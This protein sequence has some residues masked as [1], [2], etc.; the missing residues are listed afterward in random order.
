[1]FAWVSLPEGRVEGRTHPSYECG[2]ELSAF[3][4]TFGYDARGVE[5][6]AGTLLDGWKDRLIPVHG[7]ST[8]GAT[9]YCRS[10]IGSEL[11]GLVIS[12]MAH[13]YG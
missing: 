6:G 12:L 7:P 1:M 13:D 9:G 3:H 10:S 5:E 2:G 11:R 8:R 4:G